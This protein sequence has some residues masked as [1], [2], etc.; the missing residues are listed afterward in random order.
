M[1]DKVKCIGGPKD[2]EW[3]EAFNNDMV[4]VYIPPPHLDNPEYI[5]LPRLEFDPI[6][7]RKF[8]GFDRI[9][10]EKNYFD[11]KRIFFFEKSIKKEWLVPFDW[12]YSMAFDQIY[13]KQTIKKE[14]EYEKQGNEKNRC[15][16]ERYDPVTFEM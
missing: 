10:L 12:S 3:L 8:P 15:E 13:V 5:I 2:G 16:E 4:R 9:Y 7:T 6:Y 14:E 1:S 11:Y